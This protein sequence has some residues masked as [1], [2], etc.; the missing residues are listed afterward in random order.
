V[1]EQYIPGVFN[2][3]AEYIISFPG[4]QIPSPDNLSRPNANTM[5]LSFHVDDRLTVQVLSLWDYVSGPQTARTYKSC[6]NSLLLSFILFRTTI[7]TYSLKCLL[8]NYTFPE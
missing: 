4:G 3:V 1:H 6:Y 2:V 8:S 5:P 7:I